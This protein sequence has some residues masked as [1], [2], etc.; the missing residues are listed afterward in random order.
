MSTCKI[1]SV[2][3][4]QQHLENEIKQNIKYK[5]GNKLKRTKSSIHVVTEIFFRDKGKIYF[6]LNE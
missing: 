3:T 5:R 1:I 2:S 6:S 4:Y